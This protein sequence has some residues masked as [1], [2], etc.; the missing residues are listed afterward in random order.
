MS[1]DNAA[2]IKLEVPD[3]VFDAMRSGNMLALNL[4]ENI[5]VNGVEFE[6]VQAWVATDYP[7][8]A[9]NGRTAKRILLSLNNKQEENSPCPVI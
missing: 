7:A 6:V 1:F 9:I 8:H 4:H 5:T 2:K 3:E